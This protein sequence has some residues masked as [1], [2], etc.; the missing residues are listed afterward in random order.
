M[1][2]DYFEPFYNQ[3]DELKYQNWDLEQN[4]S[5]RECPK[6]TRMTGHVTLLTNCKMTEL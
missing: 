2:F 5:G 1:V 3:I 4:F 6:L